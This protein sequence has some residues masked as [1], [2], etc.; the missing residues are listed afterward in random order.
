MLYRSCGAGQ[1]EHAKKLFE[2][3]GYPLPKM[4]F[5]NV[6]SRNRQQPVSMNEQ[7]VILTGG[8]TTGIIS[9]AANGKLDPVLLMKEVLLS[10][11]YAPACTSIRI[12]N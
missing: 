6:R 11:R 2:D 3:H 10:E 7:G 9:M 12:G 8:C 5:R 4:V 1:F